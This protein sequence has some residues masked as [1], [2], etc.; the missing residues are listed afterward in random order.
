MALSNDGIV[1]VRTTADEVSTHTKNMDQASTDLMNL[2][3]NN[4]NYQ[5]FKAGT[6]KGASVDSALK[7][8]LSTITEQLTPQINALVSAIQAFLVRQAE[9]N[10]RKAQQTLQDK[11]IELQE[12]KLSAASVE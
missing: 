11:K 8:T 12:K 1:N 9:E 10:K 6:D 7:E 4:G 2:L 5:Y 3:N